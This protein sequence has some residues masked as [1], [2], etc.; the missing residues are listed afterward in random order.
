[1]A[2]YPGWDATVKVAVEVS[3][4]HANSSAIKIFIFS[5]NLAVYRLWFSL[6]RNHRL[7]NKVCS[8]TLKE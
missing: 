8:W 3:I 4:A 5:C 2:K 7:K 1:M 6:K